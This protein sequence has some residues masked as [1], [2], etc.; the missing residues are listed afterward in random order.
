MP[1]PIE[2]DLSPSWFEPPLLV[3]LHAIP[4]ANC[5]A[6]VATFPNPPEPIAEDL[7]FEFP[8][9]KPPNT[10]ELSPVIGGLLS[11]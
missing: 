8:L 7:I 3:V 6:A 11:T 1:S 5:A 2:F 9:A 4:P 10:P